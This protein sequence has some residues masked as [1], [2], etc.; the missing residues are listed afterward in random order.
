VAG[1]VVDDLLS[2]L[3][4]DERH[5]GRRSIRC[6]THRTGARGWTGHSAPRALLNDLEHGGLGMRTGMR[7]TDAT[8]SSTFHRPGTDV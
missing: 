7:T 3:G 2:D 5:G 6:L 8:S 1:E 4:L